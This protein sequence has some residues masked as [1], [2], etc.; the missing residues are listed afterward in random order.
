MHI[1]QCDDCSTNVMMSLFYTIGG[2]E[3]H[4]CPPPQ[5]DKTLIVALFHTYNYIGFENEGLKIEMPAVISSSSVP[6]PR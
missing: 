1:N 3:V 6:T 2:G 4:P 5:L